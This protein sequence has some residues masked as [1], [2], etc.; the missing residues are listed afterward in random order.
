MEPARMNEQSPEREV[1]QE[2]SRCIRFVACGMLALLV[3]ALWLRAEVLEAVGSMSYGMC[4]YILLWTLISAGVACWMGFALAFWL[5]CRVKPALL[6]MLVVGLLVTICWLQWALLAPGLMLGALAGVPE[7][8]L[9]AFF[10]LLLTGCVAVYG[11]NVAGLLAGCWRSYGVIQRGE[12][13]ACESVQVEGECWRGR[14][15]KAFIPFFLPQDALLLQVEG[16]EIQGWYGGHR[17]TTP[18][19]TTGADWVQDMQ[20]GRYCRVF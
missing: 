10:L 14:M 1:A 2:D 4:W 11:L 9:R 17:S 15:Q 20:R 12:I 6:A 8:K 19:Y 13:H 7:R 16:G 18:G 3:H 5:G